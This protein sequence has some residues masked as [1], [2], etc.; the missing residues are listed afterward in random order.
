MSIYIVRLLTFGI[1]DASLLVVLAFSRFSRRS[2]VEGLGC[3]QK[4]YSGEQSQTE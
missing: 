1:T 3:V 2:I 4:E